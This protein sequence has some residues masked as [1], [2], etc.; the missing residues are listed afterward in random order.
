MQKNAARER[1][2]TGQQNAAGSQIIINEV[3][4]DRFPTVQLFATVLKNGTPLK[5]LQ[6]NDF[7]VREDDID[8]TP[9]TVE[10]KLPPLS[11]IVLIDSSGSM[12]PRMKETKAAAGAF[13]SNLG[14]SDSTEVITFSREVRPLTPMSTNRETARHAIDS[15]RAHGDTALYDAL[16]ESVGVLKTRPGRKAVVLLSDGVDDDGKG[17]QLGK[18]SIDE[19]LHLASDVNVPLY[20]IG[21]GNEIDEALLASIAQ[22]TG[23]LYFLAP[24]AA[25]L[26]TL[27]AKIAEQLSGQ[28]LISYIS[29]HPKNSS[30][31][32]VQ[33]RY[34]EYVSVKEY[35]SPGQ[36]QITT[37]RASA[38]AAAAVVLH[39]VS[40]EGVPSWIPLPEG[41]TITNVSVERLE[42]GINGRIEYRIPQTLQTIS[43]FSQKQLATLGM[44]P[45]YLVTDTS[46]KVSAKNGQKVFELQG[47]RGS[48][49]ENLF[50]LNFSEGKEAHIPVEG[51]ATTVRLQ[52]TRKAVDLALKGA[53]QL[54]SS[55]EVS[56]G[57]IRLEQKPPTVSASPGHKPSNEPVRFILNSNLPTVADFYR[58]QIGIPPTQSQIDANGG[59]V[60]FEDD[61]KKAIIDLKPVEQNQTEVTIQI[62]QK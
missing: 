27:Y 54:G 8:Q 50:V 57:G 16:W 48:D 14:S 24:Q 40:Y 30:S 49:S 18:H 51:P 3:N 17:G 43:E 7:K 53:S 26:K 19:V 61:Q 20:A 33:I 13:L 41:A 39:N 15:I 25:Q 47:K 37:A 29:N 34:G 60:T 46:A 58:Q 36:Q 5:D 2:V 56:R 10:Q 31:H 55:V 6:A 21:V 22:G 44:R 9:L 12:K 52:G 11:I 32:Q 1:S 42:A 35:R 59:S 38:P 28:Y 4:L 23:A 45:D 62:E